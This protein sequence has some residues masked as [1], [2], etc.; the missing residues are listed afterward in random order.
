MVIFAGVV[1]MIALALL[2]QA[3]GK[4]LVKQDEARAVEQFTSCYLMLREL[5]YAGY[6]VSA[7]KCRYS[8]HGSW[9]MVVEQV[10]GSDGLSLYKHSKI[11]VRKVF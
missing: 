3:G 1:F 6:D 9:S 2:L 10:N 11:Y 4:S 5:Y 7:E 8:M